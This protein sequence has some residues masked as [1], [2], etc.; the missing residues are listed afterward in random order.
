MS[1]S[2]IAML[3][4]LAMMLT[5][6]GG[7]GMPAQSARTMTLRNVAIT[8]NGETLRLTPEAHIGVM[9]DGESAVFDFGVDADGQTLLPI[10][11]GL[12]E[13]GLTALFE[14][15][16]V[17]VNVTK[18]ALDSLTEQLGQG[19]S[20]MTTNVENPELLTFLTE[21]FMP[22]YTGMLTALSDKEF[23]ET[24]KAKS[25]E[26]L[27]SVV[28]RGEGTPD[29]AVIDDV[30]YDVLT[31]HYTID[32]AQAGQLADAL[33]A[34][35]PELSAYA[36]AMF[37]LYSM[38]PE[39][40]GLNDVKSFSDVMTK[41]GVDITME[42]DEQ[43]SEDG[44]VQVTDAVLTMDMSNLN[45]MIASQIAAQAVEE[46]VPVEDAEATDAEATDAEAADAEVAPEP[47]PT[48]EPIELEPMVWNI[49]SLTVGETTGVSMNFEY[50]VQGNAME[51]N[52]DM[53]QDATNTSMEMTGSLSQDGE[54][55]GRL[56]MSTS[57]AVNE[58]GGHSYGFSANI[59]SKD[60]IQLDV[61]F[62]GDVVADG[63]SYNTFVMD[64]RNPDASFGL[65]FEID[66]SAEPFED[67]ANA[68]EPALTIDDLSDEAMSAL[69]Q[70]QNTTALLMKVGGSLG[71]D[72][73]KLTQEKSIQNL[74][75][76]LSGERL[77]IEVE[78]E[79][80]IDYDY[81]YDIDSGEGDFVIDGLGD[82]E[83]DYEMA[84][85]DG[86]LGFEVPELSWLPQGW[87]VANVET[88]T[89]YDW[90]GISVVDDTGAEVLYATFFQDMDG[91]TTNYVVSDNGAVQSGRAMTVSD[92]GEGGM[93]VTVRENGL[94]GNLS[95]A[96]GAIDVSDIG[97]IIAGVNY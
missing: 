89:A 45:A 96:S 52:M 75:T 30:S 41:F 85:D 78:E 90:A 63:T 20:A 93:A 49:H 23:Q 50:E 16:D 77:P 17:A 21:E 88:D 2:L 42:M 64:G 73:S 76:L 39:E 4:S 95:F 40:S 67:K 31:Y 91:E 72:S 54:K 62:Y 94:Y 84:E 61:S 70:D 97:K 47:E 14:E 43:R 27:D 87:S 51:M 92:Y 53:A 65:S 36:D 74:G 13:K 44:Q 26:L 59:V 25:E 10:Q 56:Y 19:L 3:L 80:T 6:A 66:V 38:M 82:G 46:P 71:M 32:G 28:D 5:G 37:K 22:A 7:E 15:S 79:P 58:E 29:V 18:E 55:V 8:Y 68:A 86:E 69:F 11:I 24:I 60:T 9:S 48:P 81:T 57:E 34:S 83:G 12:G 35:T 33:Y 1:M